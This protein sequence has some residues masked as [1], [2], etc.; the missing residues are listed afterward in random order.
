MTCHRKIHPAQRCL[1]VEKW[2]EADQA[3]WRDVLNSDFEME[4]ERRAAW[5]PTTVQTNREGYGRWINYLKCSGADMEAAPADRVTPARV[6][7]YLEQLR[8]Q[9]NQPQTRAN[10]ISQLF[11]V[12]M[13]FAPEQNWD[14][15]K[16]RFNRL[17]G[18]AGER[19]RARTPILLS[20]DV[21]DRAFKEIKRVE[22][23]GETGPDAEAIAYRNWLMAASFM[24]LSLRRENLSDLSIQGHFR[25][26]GDEWR[27][28]IPSSEAKQKRAISMP[29][30][31]VLYRHFQFYFEHVR[32]KLL[33]G[34]ASDQVWI[35]NRHTPM[36]GHSIYIAIT[37]FTRKE[38]GM[39]ISPHEF[40]RIA[41][42][43]LVFAD[44]ENIEIGRAFLTHSDRK[45]TEKHYVIAQSVAASR[46]HGQLIASL[47][48][49]LAPAMSNQ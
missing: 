23:R 47:R 8:K 14:W 10:R 44:P 6:R 36:T 13:V 31:S 2:P 12:M 40:R 3:V 19:W 9:G 24:L 34:R 41:A 27:I 48:R 21:L 49:R 18:I 22:A 7:A 37:D 43:S 30:P 46:K 16:R 17:A 4:S 33:A 26:V 32:P 1:A 42:T 39:A 45:M 15:L 35:S 28:E 11:S 5:R 38:F 20:G 25:R 29:V